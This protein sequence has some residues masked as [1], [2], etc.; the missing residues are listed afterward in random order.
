MKLLIFSLLALAAQAAPSIFY[1]DILGGPATG[2]EFGNGAYV[3]IYGRGFGASGSVTLNG[4]ATIV[5]TWQ[6]SGGVGD[7][8]LDKACVQIGSKATSGS[9][10][11]TNASGASNPIA[12]SVVAGNIYFVATTGSDSAAGTFA[13]PWRTMLKARG[14]MAPGDITYVR[15]G[16]GQ[17]ADDGNGWSTSLLLDAN[18]GTAAAPKAFVA[19]PGESATIGSITGGMGIR[20]K[21]TGSHYWTFAGFSIL[22]KDIAVNTYNDI[23]WRFVGNDISCPNGNA[24]AGCL[25]L[26]GDGKSSGHAIFGN[27][28]HDV[29]TSNAPTLVTAL[30]HGVY[31]SETNANIDFGWNTVA[32]VFGGRCFQQH[33]NTGPGSWGISI[34]DN[35]IHHCQLDGI[36]MTTINPSKG[37]VTLRNNLIYAAGQGPANAEGSGAWNCINLQGWGPS[38]ESGT[39]D[40]S[41]N[42]LYGCGTY[43]TPPYGRS[44]GGFLWSNGNSTTK[45]AVLPKNIIDMTTGPTNNFGPA[46]YLQG[47]LASIIGNGNLFFGA[48]A[49]PLTGSLNVDPQFTNPAAGDFTLKAGSPAVGLGA[50]FVGSPIVPPILTVTP[51]AVLTITDTNPAGTTYNI[52][53]AT[54]T[55]AS[56]LLASTIAA[57]TYTDSTIVAGT[58]YIYVVEASFGGQTIKSAG[59]S[60]TVPA[61]IVLSAPAVTVAIQ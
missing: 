11:L 60:V 56:V 51:K 19:Y 9:L 50:S 3:T 59:V 5:K 52:Y 61:P 39:V 28:I 1:T 36:V 24:Q 44:S 40:V 46:V 34:H 31:L 10:V 58:S 22:G 45:G 20:S 27:Y 32:R 4:A 12:F 15:A 43:A 30:Y 26:G 42:T 55:G 13:A 2:G 7:Q 37:P 29:G 54:G 18:A 25:D 38:T 41:N 23:G 14:A 47:D 33:V 21:G 6:Q 35:I 53:R 17:T 57:K 8:P 16:A 49:A 48:G